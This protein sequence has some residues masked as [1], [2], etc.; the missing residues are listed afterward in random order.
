[1]P[2]GPANECFTKV[3]SFFVA[4]HLRKEIEQLKHELKD[5]SE[6][7]Y[8]NCVVSLPSQTQTPKLSENFFEI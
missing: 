8:S 4:K 3:K 2:E 6:I 5:V 7:Y 1:M